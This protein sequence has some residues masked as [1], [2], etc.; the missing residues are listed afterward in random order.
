MVKPAH[1]KS[2]FFTTS[3]II[4]IIFMEF[5]IK[6]TWANWNQKNHLLDDEWWSC[7]HLHGKNRGK[8]LCLSTLP[9]ISISKQWSVCMCVNVCICLQMEFRSQR[10]FLFLKCDSIVMIRRNLITPRDNMWF[11]LY[12][13]IYMRYE[14]SF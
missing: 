9:S 4:I 3:M 7:D 11:A 8:N 2:S 10:G 12:I 6:M 14:I 5:K 1:N 13:Y